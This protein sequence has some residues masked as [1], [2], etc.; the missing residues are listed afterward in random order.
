MLPC[1]L[2]KTFLQGDHE[3]SIGRHRLKL[4]R[5][6][7]RLR[8]NPAKASLWCDRGVAN[9]NSLRFVLQLLVGTSILA[10]S[11]KGERSAVG[12]AYRDFFAGHASMTNGV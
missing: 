7:E 8:F 9:P 4:A 6:H 3:V 1:W 2:N 10:G 5:M 12:L 11:S